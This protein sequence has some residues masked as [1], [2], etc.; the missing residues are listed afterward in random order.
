MHSPLHRRRWPHS[1]GS[2]ELHRGVR[3]AIDVGTVRVGVARSDPDGILAVPETTLARDDSTIA[4]IVELVTEY[5]AR[6][7]YVG[8]PI[9]LDGA[10]GASAQG[11]TAFATDLAGRVEVPVHLVDE[12]LTTVTA[13]RSMREAGRSTRES[14]AYID[15]AAAVVILENAL[16]RE[17]A[18]GTPAG[19]AVTV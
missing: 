3:L 2:P 19:Q 10:P 6:I 11:A 17:R 4:R 5:Q 7:V 9:G 13:Q 16:A 12:R 14:R 8:L 18:D 1:P 15:Q